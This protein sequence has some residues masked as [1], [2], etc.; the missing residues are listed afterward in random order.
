MSMPLLRYKKTAILII[1]VILVIVLM[2]ATATGKYK[3]SLAEGLVRVVF[4][5]IEQAVSTV[6][7]NYYPQL[8]KLWQLTGI[9][10]S[11]GSRWTNLSSP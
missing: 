3:L 5:P 2:N 11:C 10:N 9:T 4:T 6:L 7:A 1:A 8:Q